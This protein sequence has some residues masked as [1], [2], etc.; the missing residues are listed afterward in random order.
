MPRRVQIIWQGDSGQTYTI[1]LDASVR[2][3]HDTTAQVTEH[4]VER[5]S[6]IADHIRAEPRRLTIEGV[7]S[8]TPTFLPKDHVGGAQLVEQTVSVDWQGIDSTSV[9]EGRAKTLDQVTN[10]AAPDGGL[11]ASKLPI[12]TGLL[13]RIPIPDTA[14]KANVGREVPGRTLTAKVS[15]F[16][17]EFDRVRECST[18]LTRLQEE[19]IL[20]R[21][22]T[23]F[24]EYDNMAIEAINTQREAAS[25]NSWNFSMQLKNVRFGATKNEPLPVI[26]TTK[27]D[28]GTKHTEEHHSEKPQASLL[29]QTLD[30]LH[31]FHQ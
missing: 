20:C 21:V 12:P 17:Q 13:G 6:N 26:P 11:T 9:V 27:K 31:G 1:E 28:K 5:G 14:D 16:S 2:E 30:A 4:P 3:Q 24:R 29:K 15:T 23:T 10:G 22:I 25:G 8:N 18:E 7:I 19:G